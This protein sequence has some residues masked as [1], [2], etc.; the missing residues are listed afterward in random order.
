M[1]GLLCA[2][3]ALAAQAEADGPNHYAVRDVGADDVLNIRA[4]PSARAARL[5][6]IPHDGRCLRNLGCQGGL[7]MAEFTTLS[8][9][10]Q[11]ARLR[12]NPRWCRVAYGG[13]TGWVAGRYLKEDSSRCP[14]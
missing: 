8:P 10:E 2:A 9:A 1:P 12:Q 7:T 5:G 6:T 4:E 11:A 14:G 13:Q 3:L